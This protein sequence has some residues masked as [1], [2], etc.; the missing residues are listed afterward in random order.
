MEEEAKLIFEYFAQ[1]H[2]PGAP[3]QPVRGFFGE[4]ALGLPVMSL[5]L[6][7]KLLVQRRMLHAEDYRPLPDVPEV[8]GLSVPHTLCLT[9]KGV[10]LCDHLEL[11]DF[12]LSPEREFDTPEP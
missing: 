3:P 1:A 8:E 5:I 11:L 9:E 4:K 2:I 10:R 6:G 12:H 7:V